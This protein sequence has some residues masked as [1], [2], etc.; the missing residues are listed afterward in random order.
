M[1]STNGGIVQFRNSFLLGT[2]LCVTSVVLDVMGGTTGKNMS[3]RYF[4]DSPIQGGVAV[5]AG[6]EAHHLIHVMRIAVGEEVVLFDGSGVEFTGRVERVGRA[7]VRVAVV[8]KQ[9]VDRELPFDL[10]LGVPLPKGDRQKWLVEKAVELGVRRIV[11]LRTARSVA[12]PVEH[13]L[14]RLERT[15][16]EASKQCGRNRLLEIEEPSRWAEFVQRTG[17]DA[18]RWIAHPG[19]QSAQSVGLSSART[20]PRASTAMVAIGPEG[21][22]GDEEVAL[23]LAAGW[24]PVDLGPRILRIETAAVWLCALL[25]HAFGSEPRL[26]EDKMG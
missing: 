21:G 3:D 15:V 25:V 17:Q 16:I 24:Q 1:D 6:Q 9:E 5:L 23:A 19:G 10:T 11:P 4:V 2:I 18:W 22:F 12:Q 7:E 8:A 26:L 20:L 13:A 14:A